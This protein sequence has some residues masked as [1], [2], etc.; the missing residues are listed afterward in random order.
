MTLE[1]DVLVVGGGPAG[2]SAARA[3][4]KK[5]AKTI[6]IEKQKRITNVPCAE[7][8]GSYLFPLL[9]FKIPKNQ[10]LWKIDGIAF[11]DG[12]TEIIQHGTFYRG[13]SIEREKFDNWL[14]NEAK[15]SGAQVLMN[16]ECINL[17]LSKEKIVNQIEIKQKKKTHIIQPKKIIAADGV[18]SNIAR[19]LGIL[20]KTEESVGHVYSWEMKNVDIKY[21]HYEQ[22]Y[23]GDFAPRA[24]AYVFPKSSTNANI[25]VGSTK[26]EK[27][28]EN[29][30]EE[31]VEGIIHPQTKNA[32]K[33]VNRSG[34]APIKNMIPET[35][36]GNVIFTG[37]AANQNFKPYVE[38]ILP[39]IICGDIAGKAAPSKDNCSYED[40]IKT[41]LG[42][43]FKQSNKILEKMYDYDKLPK[44]KKNL[45]NMYLFAFMDID[46]IEELKSKDIDTIK[47]ELLS[48]SRHVNSFITMFQYFIWYAKVLTTRRD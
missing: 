5:G 35:I 25:G 39:S 9:P 36:Y 24:Y 2:S 46:K 44:K 28:L 48:K 47:S 19:N 17:K 27:K 13:W 20:Q 16:T 6:L 29:Y 3:A 21:P 1:C 32:V 12:E 23:F 22:M 34:K 8:I 7:G 40:L 33:T 26:G 18:E 4:A 30:F 42:K 45:I 43:Q 41:K 31:F 15:N 38:G 37:D 14:L 11:S 10:L